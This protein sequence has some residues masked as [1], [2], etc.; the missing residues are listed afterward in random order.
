MKFELLLGR[1]VDKSFEAYKEFVHEIS[2]NLGVAMDKKATEEQ[3]KKGW[4][5][6]WQE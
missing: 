1:P 5:E 6:F 3:L 4:Q 2:A